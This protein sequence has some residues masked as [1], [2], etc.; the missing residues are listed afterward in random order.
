MIKKILLLQTLILSCFF[1]QAQVYLADTAFTTGT[2]SAGER[3]SALFKPNGNNFGIIMNARGSVAV[4]DNFTI[5]AGQTW[6]LDTVILYGYQPG[7]QIVSTITGATLR[8]FRDSVTGLSI[9]GD[10]TTNRMAASGW[11]GFYRVDTGIGT[12]NSRQ[13]PVMYMKIKLTP[14]LTLGAGTYWMAWSAY[15]N[16]PD[17]PYCPP[18]VLPGQVNPPGQDGKQFDNGNG[19]WVNC[20]DSI[21]PTGVQRLGFNFI[22]K[23]PSATGINGVS[24]LQADFL[25]VPNPVQDKATLSFSLNNPDE[26]NL[27]LYDVTGREVRTLLEKRLNKGRHS[28]PF[29]VADLPSGTYFYQLKTAHGSAGGQMEIKH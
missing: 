19:V 1:A 12:I 28:V 5:P 6:D 13:R 15:G 16:F 7:T 10:A 3:V 2:N 21:S 22:L 17:G 9:F 11:A 24:R 8:I 23:G 25:L 27:R 29:E 14:T 26:V 18:K 20:V 4:A